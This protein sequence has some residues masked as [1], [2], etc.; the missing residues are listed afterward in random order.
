[1]IF[2]EEGDMAEL[3]LARVKIFDTGRQRGREKEPEQLRGTLF[4]RKR[5]GT[6][7]SCLKRFL[8]SPRPYRILSG[9][10]FIP[11]EGKIFLEDIKLGGNFLKEYIKDIYSCLRNFIS[12]GACGEISV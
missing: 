6:S 8:S 5:A 1:M 10:G 3:K 4:R 12:R 2:L 7:I 9:E 11:E